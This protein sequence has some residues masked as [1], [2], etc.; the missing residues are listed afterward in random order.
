MSA[1]IRSRCPKS[2]KTSYALIGADGTPV[3]RLK[4]GTSV[5]FYGP[6]TCVCASFWP[7]R[8]ADRSLFGPRVTSL[9]LLFVIRS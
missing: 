1:T 3:L 6:R 9:V 4:I 7:V 8:D 2:L 5:S